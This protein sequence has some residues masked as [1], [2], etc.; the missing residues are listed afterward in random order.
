MKAVVFTLGCKVNECESDSLIQGLLDYGYEV[1]DKLETAD[2]YIINSCAVTKDAE[3]KSR[4]AVA[5][6][7]SLNPKA[8]VILTGCASQKAPK[9]FIS[10]KGVSVVTGTFG[11][12]N[13]L[14]LLSSSGEFI[15]SEP[16]KYEEL[17]LPKTLRTRTYV[18]V[19][20]GCNN[21]C[22]YCVIPYLRGRERSRD[23]QSIINEI[24]EIKP[25]EAVINGI[26]LSA[27]NYEGKGLQGLICALKPVETRIRLGSLEAR[28]VTK[29]LLEALKQL[30]NF[31]PH[32]HLSL[33]SGSDAV[34]KSMN[35]HYSTSSYLE[36]VNLIKSYFPSAGI[37]TDVIVGFPTETEEN[38]LE[39]VEFIRKVGFSDIHPFR[40][41]PREGTVAFKMKDLGARV[42]KERIE[43][44]LNLKKELKENFISSQIGTVQEFLKEEFKQGYTVGYTGNYLRVYVKGEVNFE[45]LVK[46]KIIEKLNDGAVAE[47]LN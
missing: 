41:S 28:V 43:V 7:L 2:I 1:T 13:I 21:F 36:K 44:L 22:S 20:D 34:L 18:K 16:S 46:V 35:R 8:K 4:Q 25:K 40:F 45:N 31:A 5:R 37:T 26:N 17:P 6:A 14:T 33:Q 42:K 11:K 27:Y 23:Y 3:K 19:Q 39:S 29:E 9:D 15:Y 10:K 12:Q 47:I 30:K 38:F 24:N 32:F